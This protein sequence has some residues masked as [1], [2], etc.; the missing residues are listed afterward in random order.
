MAREN[1]TRR[2]MLAG[3]LFELMHKT[4][5]DMRGLRVLLPSF[6]GDPHYVFL[7]LPQF[8]GISEDKYRFVRSQF[9]QA[10]CLVTKLRFP[11]ALDIIGIATESG[12]SNGGR[13]EDSCY[14]NAREWSDEDRAEALSLQK[15]LE[16][17]VDPTPS[18]T[19]YLEYP[20]E[21]T[22]FDP[23]IMR[24]SKFAMKG[25]D[26]NSP[27]ICGSGRKF[28]KCCGPKVH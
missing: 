6:P 13:S 10:C 23:R 2:R 3:A 4:S 15:D 9:L 21:I 17:L 27:C 26:R 25:R 5:S 8:E 22:K 12:L 19:T 18:F 14:Y 20:S 1:R 16:I 7:L 24:R 11:K 28:K